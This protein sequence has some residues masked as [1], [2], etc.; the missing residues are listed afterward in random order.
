ML[1]SAI[2][3]GTKAFPNGVTTWASI[4]AT[5]EKACPKA[6]ILFHFIF[7]ILSIIYMPQRYETAFISLL[8]FIAFDKNYIYQ[9]T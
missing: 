5:T 7:M 3:S 1:A 8:D 6:I 2:I 9:F 4:M